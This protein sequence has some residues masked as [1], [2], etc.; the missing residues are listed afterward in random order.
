MA[1]VRNEERAVWTDPVTGVREEALF[2]GPEGAVMVLAH[3][4]PGPARGRVVVCGSLGNEGR[5]NNLRE[6]LLGRRLASA[7]IAVAR[8]NYR[9]SGSSGDVRG[10][11]TLE[12][13]REDV[14]AAVAALGEEGPIGFV[15]TRWGGLVAAVAAAGGEAPVT[16]WDPAVEGRRYF[17]EM[18]KIRAVEGLAAEAG[19]GARA[20]PP[21][22]DAAHG[23]D[24]G[25]WIAAPAQGLANSAASRTLAD[26][27]ARGTGPVLLVQASRG[28]ALRPEYRRTV[29]ALGGRDVETHILPERAIWWFSAPK[30]SQARLV[31]EAV[32]LIDLT[33]GW[34]ERRLT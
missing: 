3:R 2:A 23:A 22:A 16:L 34:L 17:R 11:S 24:E 29:E 1:T 4:P 6:A 28:Q 10:G 5:R 21:G 31:P 8:L 7:G 15:G 32:A 20:D 14:A 19:F 13:Q 26:E 9:G 30:T 33:A 18:S 25:E 27:L 12:T